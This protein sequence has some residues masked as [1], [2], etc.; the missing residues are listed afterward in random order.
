METSTQSNNPFATPNY[1]YRR[2]RGHLGLQLHDHSQARQLRHL[3]PDD[4][5]RSLKLRTCQMDSDYISRG[6]RHKCQQVYRIFMY[7]WELVVDHCIAHN[8]IFVAP[9]PEHFLFYI[10]EMTEEKVSSLLAGK[11]YQGVNVLKS[12]G[13]IYEFVFY[14]RY[15]REN[16]RYRSVR[17]KYSKY[18]Q[19][20]QRVNAG[21]RYPHPIRDLHLADLMGDLG[22]R[23]P[24]MPTRTLRLVV[25]Y[26]CLGVFNGMRANEEVFLEARNK[27]KMM[28]LFYTPEYNLA[29]AQRQLRDTR[30]KARQQK[31]GELDSEHNELV[32][33][34]LPEDD[35]L[36]CP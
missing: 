30:H 35:N 21:Q 26:G 32:S 23:F 4:F 16:H 14:S 6:M 29:V 17:I 25:R 34:Q 28:V 31:L 36:S 1:P 11:A 9:I 8:T 18:K 19:L 15:L 10:R 12:G 5:V 2:Q 7:F 3:F 27:V 22:K 24:D 33:G 20:L 13:K